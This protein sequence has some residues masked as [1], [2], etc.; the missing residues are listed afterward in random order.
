MANQK[1]TDK[2]SLNAFALND[3]FHVVDVSDTSSDPAGT[4]KKA[5]I[6]L[7]A[8]YL[9]FLSGIG[10]QAVTFEFTNPTISSGSASIQV[11]A[12]PGANIR[13]GVCGMIAT[14]V[15]MS[16][17]TGNTSVAARYSGDGADLAGGTIF[18]SGG[19]NS[20]LN[21]FSNNI[22]RYVDVSNTAINV[23]LTNGTDQSFTGTVKGVVFYTILDVS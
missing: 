5:T 7:L 8:N 3:L 16:A 18:L 19:G 11:L 15:G 20:V 12:A 13:Y 14:S 6:Q 21:A 2:T 22:T 17:G 23:L 4:S 1:L 9:S 10:M